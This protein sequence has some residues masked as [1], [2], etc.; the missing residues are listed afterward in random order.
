LI[1]F[2]SLSRLLPEV[3][4]RQVEAS[5]VPGNEIVMK[6]LLPLPRDGDTKSVLAVSGRM[7]IGTGLLSKVEEYGNVTKAALELEKAGEPVQAPARVVFHLSHVSGHESSLLMK[8]K[9]LLAY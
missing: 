9:V 4:F 7:M 1:L 6:D 2:P 8:L 3:D 5:E